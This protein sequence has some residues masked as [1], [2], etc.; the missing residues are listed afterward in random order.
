M[1]E[2]DP[3]GSHIEDV[4]FDNIY[5]GQAPT[6]VPNVVGDNQTYGYY[7]TGHRMSC[8]KCHD[9]T[10]AH[11][12]GERLP[13]LEYIKNTPNP[14]NFRFYDDA[15]KQLRLPYNNDNTSSYNNEDFA[16]CYWCHSETN[17][18]G[19]DWGDGTNFKDINYPT[20][21]LP[22]NYH[23][24]HMYLWV[25]PWPQ[26]C[27]HCHDPHGQFNPAMTRKEMGNSIA[28]DT[29]GCEILPG[30][31]SDGDG[32][33]D[34]HDPDVNTGLALQSH[35]LALADG[36][37]CRSC[38]DWVAPPPNQ[39]PCN[40]GDD[41]Y[42]ITGCLEGFYSRSYERV[43][44]TVGAEVDE[45]CGVAGCHDV[46]QGSH[47]THS[48]G[49]A[50]GPDPLDCR[51]CH[52]DDAMEVG[53]MASAGACDTCH[54]PNGAFD[55]VND[56]DIG[57]KNC[58]NN[59][60]EAD[61]E[62]LLSGKEQWCATCHDDVPALSRQGPGLEVVVDNPAATFVCT[63]GTSASGPNLPAADTYNV[64]AWWKASPNR[65]TDSPYT[66][67]YDGGSATVDVNQEINGNQWNLLGSYPFAAGT[68][69]YVVL[70]DDADQYVIADA[71]KFDN[72]SLEVSIN[73]P[74]VTGD[75]TTYGYYVTGHDIRC[76]SCHNAGSEHIDHAHRTYDAGVTAFGDSYRLK[77]PGT[78]ASRY[79]CFVCHNS[80]EVLGQTSSDVS[81]TNFWNNDGSIENAHS[82]HMEL[83][84]TYFDSD[85]DG[86][87]DTRNRCNACHN[88]HGSP[89]PA[90][91]RHGELIS[92]PGTTDKVPALNFRYLGSATLVGST[93]GRM[94]Y[95]GPGVGQNGV[96]KSCHSAISYSRTPYLGPMVSA[97]CSACGDPVANDGSGTA[98][99]TVVV[100]DPDGD[101][102]TVE[103]DLTPIG[104]I[105]NQ[106]MT[107]GMGGYYSYLVTIPPGTPDSPLPF[108]I[109]ATDLAANTGEGEVSLNVVDPNSIYV[110][111][112]DAALVCN[113]GVSGDGGYGGLT[114][115]YSWHAAGTGTCTAT[116]T[117]NVPSADTYNV[118]AWWKASSNRAT[119]SPYTINYDG[120]SATVEVNQEIGGSQWNYLG[121]FSF[122]AGTSGSVVLSD[123]ANEY[124]IADAI[125]LTPSAPP[126]PQTVIVDNPNAQFAGSWGRS[127]S[128]GYPGHLILL[129]E[130][131][132]MFMPGGGPLQTGPRIPHI[133]STMMAALRLLMSTRRQAVISGIYWESIHLPPGNRAMWC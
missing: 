63:W 78:K 119:D 57:A 97:E 88:V 121:N 113:W 105:P 40:P 109:T 33:D 44:H 46:T 50:K 85:F 18:I 4:Y 41:P 35:L 47:A 92:T 56:P 48:Q 45:S 29:N 7:V 76:L 111:N 87:V 31:D 77:V 79:F 17:L 107:P 84:G 70:S 26:S 86:A 126:P 21:G 128:G 62:T 39:A 67:H 15:T 28:F 108:V 74:N 118:Y 124:V 9:S 5:C 6:G 14:T 53:V 122:A 1:I 116:W 27:V 100:S 127:P 51:D 115:D 13:I 133:R 38:H 64:R 125:K 8:T 42:E 80:T 114:G 96:C 59:V 94:A 12:D 120:G 11:I 58:W 71:V 104:G 131:A 81:H 16:L 32:V 69:G 10:S 95:A 75:N 61:G 30:A 23:Y 98:T 72:S 132:T 110:D 90:M 43:P 3:T 91:I 25:P 66:I 117:P 54:S 2:N 106:A 103:I 22:K 24:L 99:I 60:Y 52:I 55:G 36:P 112:A 89:T 130:P 73:A 83:T 49:T 93:G 34:R 19:D 102:S 82:L 20:C 101:V 65:A 68:S 129:L 37:I 123:D